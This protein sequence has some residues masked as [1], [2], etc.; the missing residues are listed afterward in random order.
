[1]LNRFAREFTGMIS[2][3]RM[4]AV[5]RNAAELGVSQKQL[6]E[7]SGNAVASVVSEIAD[8]GD[9][10]TVVAGRG[11]NGGD[12]CV[13]ARFLEEYEVVTVLIGRPESIGTE[14]ARANWEA[15]VA[16]EHETVVVQDSSSFAINGSS[17]VVDAV[18]GTGITGEPRE[19]EKTVISRINQSEA[20][21]VSV[22]VPSGL[23]ADTGEG[24]HVVMADH[25]ATFHDLKPALASL[26]NSEVHVFDIGIPGAAEVFVGPGDLASFSRDSA[27]HKG[28]HGRVHIV[29][30]GP[31]T[32]APALAGLAALRAGAD[33]SFVSAPS[34][35]SRE[36]QGFSP[37][38]I[39]EPYDE[40]H[41]TPEVVD[42]L[43]DVVVDRDVVVLGPGL[44]EEPETL[45]AVEEFLD[46]Y[47]GK[48]VI[49]A[50]A[51]QRVP[52][53]ETSATLVCTPHQGELVEM[54]GETSS[55]WEERME[56]V[57]E[58]AESLGQVL[59]VK[60]AYDVISDGSVTRA[61]RTGNPGMAVGGTGDVLAG[62]TGALLA[63]HSPLTAAA[64]GAYVNGA[65]GD[66]YE[67]EHGYGLLASDLLARIPRVM[68]RER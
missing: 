50:D 64:V 30:G 14:I 7:S 37:D 11:N 40:S 46:A 66:A 27:G 26:E 15:L 25:V 20:T 62:I 47:S 54:G 21:V 13:A 52:E 18:L 29:G 56:L 22:D 4:A 1:M 42:E 24:E 35:I 53:S 65:A 12:G 39:V 8:P 45:V 28:E 17:V 16:S 60:G 19:P 2:S 41:L 38:L 68:W 48:A 36:I 51:L 67:A 32:G 10:V 9:E 59:L 34:E 63:T 55:D 23:N 58:Y 49:D 57:A 31:Y 43:L 3:D 33:L 61:N 6:M 44:G 5:D